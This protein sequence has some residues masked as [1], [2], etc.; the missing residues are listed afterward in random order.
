MSVVV[1][2][3]VAGAIAL[4]DGNAL[5][6]SPPRGWTVMAKQEP[7]KVFLAHEDGRDGV[8]LDANVASFSINRPVDVSLQQNPI[9]TWTWRVDALPPDGDFR[10]GRTDDQ[11]AQMFVIFERSGLRRRAINYIW[12]THASVGEA[13]TDSVPLV[14]SIKTLVVKSGASEIGRW[15]RMSRDVSRDYADLFGPGTVPR[16]EAVRFQV[17]SQHTKSHA[18]G[19]LAEAEFG[20]Q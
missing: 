15:V 1:A 14:I 6:S 19:C 5:R 11:A 8:C 7:V 9:L 18:V 10:Q 20:P 13:G 12:D 17:N 4:L 16:V 3:I 2:F